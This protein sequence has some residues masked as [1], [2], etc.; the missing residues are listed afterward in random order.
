MLVMSHEHELEGTGDM[1]G[2]LRLTFQDFSTEKSNMRITTTTPTAANLDTWNSNIA[3]LKTALAA[4][5]LGV[6]MSEQRSAL[7]DLIDSDPPTNELAQR[8]SKW[9]VTY[10]GNTSEKLFRT[11]IPTADIVGHLIAASDEA[12]LA[13]ADIAAFVAAFEDVVRSPDNGTEACTVLS[14]RVVGRNL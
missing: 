6:L 10:K 4:I 8:E 3:A 2:Q 12:D 9:L 5:T 13:N 11:E 7:L 1:A 14:I